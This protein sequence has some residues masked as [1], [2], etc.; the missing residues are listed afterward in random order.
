MKDEKEPRDE[1]TVGVT[2]TMLY[3]NVA[4][5]LKPLPHGQKRGK[6]V[7]G[8]DM[9]TMTVALHFA[10]SDTNIAD[11]RLPSK[12]KENPPHNFSD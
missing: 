2:E 9:A 4:T 3:P 12:E 11:Y 5:W 6:A 1:I 7:K 8:K 10:S